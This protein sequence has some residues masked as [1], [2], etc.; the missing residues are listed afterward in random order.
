MLGLTVNT[1]HLNI[2]ES[3]SFFNINFCRA[4]KATGFPLGSESTAN[5]VV[6]SRIPAAVL[7]NI[8]FTCDLMT[9]RSFASRFLPVMRQMHEYY[10][11]DDFVTSV[12]NAAVQ[13]KPLL[14]C[15]GAVF[16]CQF[17]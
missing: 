4:S 5:T 7:G 3:A 1:I 16:T 2:Y 15:T 8:D 14:T 6:V 13:P 9:Y 17:S 11:A 10:S 12:A